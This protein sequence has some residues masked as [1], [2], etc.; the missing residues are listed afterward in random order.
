MQTCLAMLL[1]LSV[2]QSEP[3]APGKHIRKLSMAG[4]SRAYVVHVPR[5][6]EPSR[7]TPVVVALHGAAMNGL[8]MEGFCGLSRKANEAGFIV[9]YP[10]G[11][12]LGG[13]LLTW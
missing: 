8:L 7:P 6:Y 10:D 9:V 4:Q 11:T 2:G 12:G 3:L 1:A 5:G 13:V